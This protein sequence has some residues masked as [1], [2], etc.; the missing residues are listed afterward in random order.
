MFFVST[1]I[2]TLIPY[3]GGYAFIAWY[4]YDS[5]INPYNEDGEPYSTNL[6][7]IEWYLF[8][9]IFITC[10]CVAIQTFLASE[11]VKPIYDWW[12]ILATREDVVPYIRPTAEEIDDRDNAEGRPA[13]EP[14]DF[15]NEDDNGDDSV[16]TF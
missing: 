12:Q 8:V 5:E 15:E 4:I 7:Y 9:K 2:S 14:T 6:S 3:F 1:A 11:M 13:D 16:I 10:A